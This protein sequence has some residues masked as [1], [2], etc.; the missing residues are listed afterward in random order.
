MNRNCPSRPHGRSRKT[1]G[2]GA[3]VLI[4]IAIAIVVLILALVTAHIVYRPPSLDGRTVSRAV[5]A[6]A[7]TLLGRLALS[8][9]PGKETQSGFVPL[10][11][12]PDAFAAR[13][14]PALVRAGP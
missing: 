14:A 10:V 6:S 2:N 13:I 12:G 4:K 11:D 1:S 8:A 5:E 3:D 9:P 7:A